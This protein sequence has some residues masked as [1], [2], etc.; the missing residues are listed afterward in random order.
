[1]VTE[2]GPETE[3]AALKLAARGLRVLPV[4]GIVDGACTCPRGRDCSSPGKHPHIRAWQE[5]ATTNVATIRDWWKR[6]PSGNVGVAAG[7]ESGVVV[8][9]IDAKSGGEDSL[10][11]LIAERG[12]LPHTP[13]VLTGGG[14]RHLY[15]QHPGGNIPNSAGRLGPGVDIRGEGGFVVAPPSKHQSGKSYEWE[16]SSHFEDVLPAPIPA[17][18]IDFLRPVAGGQSRSDSPDVPNRIPRGKRNPTLFSM[19]GTMRRRGLDAEEIQGALLVA[20]AKRCDPPLSDEE[21]ASIAHGIERY[22]PADSEN[23]VTGGRESHEDASVKES[24]SRVQSDGEDRDDL[25]DIRNGRRLVSLHGNDLRHCDELGWLAWDGRRWARARKEAT[26]RA[27]SVSSALR[28]EARDCNEATQ[29]ELNRLAKRAASAKG[30]HDL[31]AMAESEPAV[32]VKAEQFD[33]DLWLLNVRNGTLDLR[34]GDLRSHR[35]VDLITKFADVQFDAS[36]TCPQWEAFLETVLPNPEV[37]AFV[38]RAVGYSLTGSVREQVMLLLYGTGANG[39]STFLETVRS[40]VGDYGQ[41]TP[42]ETLLQRHAGAIP[43]DVA[44]LRGARF[45][46]SIE[47]DQGRRMA[48]VMV[49]Q[50]TGADT[51]SARF[52][53]QEW[54]E[55]RPICKIWLATNRKPVV[56]GTD[57][58]IW[59]RIRLVPFTVSIPEPERDKDLLLKLREELPGILNWALEGC[60]FWQRD[61]LG[62]PDGVRVATAMYRAEM[63]VLGSFIDECCLIDDACWTYTGPLNDAY[64]SWC[65]QNGEKPLSTRAFAQRLQERGFVNK[66]HGP[67]RRRAWF[68]LGLLEQSSFD[69]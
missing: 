57:E 36:A 17:W 35:Q 65:D 16:A 10:D 3:E 27:K 42:A 8:L 12:P 13:E 26:E 4:H 48:E 43:N 69:G 46:V 1:M 6:R 32:N 25:G 2:T 23:L 52:M 68:G 60:R 54:F 7:A 61:S 29:K 24:A 31:L 67:K 56:R 37:R 50:L 39:K 59:R 15:F 18:L 63:D 20:N 53:R 41:Q 28:R 22:P 66:N 64:K 30:V 58:A 38:Q 49:K 33:T 47:T 21:I 5:K 34:T 11:A 9:D 45:V 44:R 19:A 62:M 40:V 51:I 55:F 14:G